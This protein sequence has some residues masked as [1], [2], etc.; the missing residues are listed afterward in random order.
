MKKDIF[1]AFRSEQGGITVLALFLVLAALIVGG[2][3]VDIARLAA[4]ETKMQN[5]AD[6]AAQA[7]LT[8]RDVM[9]ADDAKDRAIEIAQMNMPESIN[10]EVLSVEKVEFG[11][12]D[13]TSK[14]FSPDNAA[15]EA[16]RVTTRRTSG[17][18][19][20][21]HTLLFRL[22]GTETFNVAKQAVMTG[23]QP[24]CL[25]EGFVAQ[26]MVDIQSNNSY[27]KGFCIHSNTVVK[28]SSNNYF[29]TGVKVTMPDPDAII[30]P[31][32][33]FST[34]P[35]LKEALG[36]DRYEIKILPRLTSIMSGVT[37][38]GSRYMPSY[39]TNSTPVSKSGSKFTAAD[40]PAGGV[41]RITCTKSNGITI[42]GALSNVVITT[43]CPIGFGQG[44]TIENAVIATTSTA[45]KSITGSSG[46]VIGKADNCASGG[47]AQILTSGGIDFASGIE[48][49]SGQLLAAGDIAFA[50]NGNG[51]VGASFV[52]GGTISGTSNMEMA[53]CQG[54]GNEQNF[55]A[56]YPKLVL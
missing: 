1:A 31:N 41:Y 18:D 39:I 43:T 45:T 49:N 9:G 19:N 46:M 8:G 15:T 55:V 35:G 40:F 5:T 33:G 17:T 24:N 54:S 21:L 29:E 42:T 20:P 52:A 22:V 11:T 56:I 7:A 30:L 36:K 48:V 34:N 3:A 47:G 4:V 53:G 2:Y 10:G 16:V 13:T 37:T 50:A 32:S 38:A 23:Y 25:R 14:V 26:G 6:V 28:M 51:M 44:T 27:W 12:W